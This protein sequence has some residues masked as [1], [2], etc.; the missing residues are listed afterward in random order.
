MNTSTDQLDGQIRTLVRT[1]AF[2]AGAPSLDEIEREVAVALAP[3]AES[4][5]WYRWVAVAAVMLLTLTGALVIT[6]NRASVNTP[7]EVPPPADTHRSLGTYLDLVQ[8]R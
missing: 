1:A 7:T 5:H 4:H 2:H 8:R 6:R 3:G